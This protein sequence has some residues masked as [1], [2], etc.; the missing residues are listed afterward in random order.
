[1]HPSSRGH[2]GSDV[3]HD[4]AQR[5]YDRL[6]MRLLAEAKREKVVK[7]LRSALEEFAGPVV[8]GITTR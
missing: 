5:W 6:P 1:M 2:L 3:L 7:A 4:E 8:A